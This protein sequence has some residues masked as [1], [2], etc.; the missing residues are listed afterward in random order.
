MTRA[1]PYVQNIDSIWRGRR[2]TT[3]KTELGPVNQAVCNHTNICPTC[4]NQF[5]TEDVNTVYCSEACEG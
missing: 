2:V 5:E 1:V 3:I 4:N